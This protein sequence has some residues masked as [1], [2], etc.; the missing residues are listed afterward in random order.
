MIII[1]AFSNI[2]NSHYH[3]Q[4]II[5][6]Q[7]DTQVCPQLKPMD[8]VCR[9]YVKDYLPLAFTLL[10]KFLNAEAICTYAYYN[11]ITHIIL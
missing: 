6:K 7:L 11:S 4:D 3:F 8:D 5:A 9:A 10:S 1:G 2:I